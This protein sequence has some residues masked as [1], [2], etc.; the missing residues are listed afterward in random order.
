MSFE[1]RVVL[2]ADSLVHGEALTI[3]ELSLE[4]K[5]LEILE[6]KLAVEAVMSFAH[7]LVELVHAS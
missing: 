3:V 7:V 4:R 1:G 6:T 5:H 2:V